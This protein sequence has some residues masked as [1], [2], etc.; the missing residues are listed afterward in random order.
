MENM[1]S[2]RKIN[3][4][5]IATIIVVC[6]LTI[7]LVSVEMDRKQQKGKI[8][9]VCKEYLHA[10]DTIMAIPE[11]EREDLDKYVEKA[12]NTIKPY[13]LDKKEVVDLQMKWLTDSLK[14]EKENEQ[15][16]KTQT[17]ELT[18]IS[19]YQFDNDQVRVILETKLTK[20]VENSQGEVH[21][22]T[23]NSLNDEIILKKEGDTWK[24]VYASLSS[25]ATIFPETV[26]YK[27]F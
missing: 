9:S 8:E 1:R 27:S 12:K 6:I 25:V 17:N 7:Y 2:L 20:E 16:I 18:K 26:M 19:K 14:Q 11:Q 21:H 4:G 10:Y 24:V 3:K 13:L 23:S 15:F 5:L 22:N